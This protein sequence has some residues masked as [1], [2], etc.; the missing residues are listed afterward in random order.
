MVTSRKKPVRRTWTVYMAWA[1]IDRNGLFSV[2]RFRSNL[3]RH[4]NTEVRRCRVIVES[5]K[6]RMSR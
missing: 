5:R 1:T 6:R 2:S 4:P 3:R